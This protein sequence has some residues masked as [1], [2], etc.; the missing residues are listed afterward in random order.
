MS[1]IVIEANNRGLK[2]WARLEPDGFGGQTVKWMGLKDNATDFETRQRAEQFI[3]IARATT[4]MT[5][6]I[7][8]I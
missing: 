8:E 7:K 4:S 3:S 2:Y 6:E 1:K 5:V